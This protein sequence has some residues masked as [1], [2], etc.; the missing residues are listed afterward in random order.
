MIVAFCG[1]KNYYGASPD[2]KLRIKEIFEKELSGQVDFY[3]GGYCSFENLAFK[4]ARE[5]QETHPDAKLIFITP[6]LGP[7][8]SR[9]ETAKERYD[10]I[11]YPP[12]ETVPKRLAILRR[13]DWIVKQSDI[14]IGH[15]T[16]TMGNAF[17]MFEYAKKQKKKVFNIAKK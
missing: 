9:L 8:Y 3:F 10:E 6:Y 5:Y 2:D 1:H 15:I 14:V 11:I 16:R 17:N 4:C 13:N 12:L 7:H